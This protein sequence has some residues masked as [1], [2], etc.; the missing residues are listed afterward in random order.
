MNC[1]SKRDAVTMLGLDSTRPI[2]LTSDA[3]S[4]CLM[5]QESAMASRVFTQQATRAVRNFQLRAIQQPNPHAEQGAHSIVCHAADQLKKREADQGL[6]Q[7]L[8][9]VSACTP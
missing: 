8:A 9:A 6:A 5:Q 1:A 3:L 7:V 2:L 4:C